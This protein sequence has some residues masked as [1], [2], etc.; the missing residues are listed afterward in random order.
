MV[1]FGCNQDRHLGCHDRG[2]GSRLWGL[3]WSASMAGTADQLFFLLLYIRALL[4]ERGL[5]CVV[6]IKY[7]YAVFR[8]NPSLSIFTKLLLPAQVGV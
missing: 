1:C 3:F 8:S 2:C 6:S 5:D 7:C 4:V